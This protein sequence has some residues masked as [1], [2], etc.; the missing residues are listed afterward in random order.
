VFDTIRDLLRKEAIKY[1]VKQGGVKES[2]KKGARQRIIKLQ[3]AIEALKDQAI[4]SRVQTDLG[5]KY[6]PNY[7]DASIKRLEEEIKNLEAM[8]NWQLPKQQQPL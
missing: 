4:L 7:V 1:R 3:R 6:S 8:L 2:T 5:S